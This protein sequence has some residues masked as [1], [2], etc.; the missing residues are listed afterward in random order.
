MSFNPA[1]YSTTCNKLCIAHNN[2]AVYN[3]T[4]LG[5]GSY[6]PEGNNLNFNPILGS[7]ILDGNNW[8][9]TSRPWSKGLEVFNML[10]L[11]KTGCM[12]ATGT[13]PT[14]E[15]YINV[16]QDLGAGTGKFSISGWGN[17]A[18]VSHNARGA[19]AAYDIRNGQEL[20]REYLGH[21]GGSAPIMVN[22]I[23]YQGFG[24]QNNNPALTD[25]VLNDEP[26]QFQGCNHMVMYTNRGI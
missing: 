9:V 20:W 25:P 13:V 10:S 14:Y 21:L 26:N 16:L 7:D 22:D 11:G 24:T 18:L 2:T 19:I 1:F 3:C 23:M 5:G 17:C 4:A 8:N 6:K 15:R 12:S